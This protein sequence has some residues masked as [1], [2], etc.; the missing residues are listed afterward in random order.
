[1][2]ENIYDDGFPSEVA[3]HVDVAS[4]Y[5]DNDAVNTTTGVDVGYTGD[6][7][8]AHD[9][10]NATVTRLESVGAEATNDAI[11]HWHRG[12]QRKH[13]SNRI[14][15]SDS[16]DV[17]KCDTVVLK[18]STRVF[19]ANKNPNRASITVTN[20]S[21][22]AI[23][24]GGESATTLGGPG[25]CSIPAGAFRT[26]YHTAKIYVVGAAGSIVDI[27]EESYA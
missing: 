25:T 27:A 10:E 26:F 6:V 19:L 5:F 23:S 14:P 21:A 15:V 20:Q 13:S 22:A 2:T 24:V 8:H 4:E 11:E 17:F 7:Q 9:T 18:S 16:P 3:G 12:E 1:M